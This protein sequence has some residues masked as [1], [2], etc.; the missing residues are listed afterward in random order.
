[1]G[2]VHNDKRPRIFHPGSLECHRHKRRLMRWMWIRLDATRDRGSGRAHRGLLGSDWFDQA[3]LRSRAR[4]GLSTTDRARPLAGHE[5]QRQHAEPS[6]AGR[7][8]RGRGGR[9]PGLSESPQ[10]GGEIAAML[11]TRHRS[12]G[13]PDAAN[14]R[15]RRHSA[16]HPGHVRVTAPHRVAS[17]RAPRPRS[18]ICSSSSSDDPSDSDD[19]P[20]RRGRVASPCPRSGP[21]AAPACAVARMRWRTSFPDHRGD[22][23]PADGPGRGEEGSGEHHRASP[24]G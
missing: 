11:P 24:R 19:L 9:F 16:S 1:M 7:S 22:S 5:T 4:F 2:C 14:G 18:S 6:G 3:T 8:D 10:S 23:A 13:R 15:Q 20:T 17:A 12:A 21:A